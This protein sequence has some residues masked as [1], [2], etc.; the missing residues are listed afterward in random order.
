MSTIERALAPIQSKGRTG[1][2]VMLVRLAPLPEELS[3]QRP[4]FG[5]LLKAL[6][7]GVRYWQGHLRDVDDKSRK[8]DSMEWLKE[9]AKKAAV[10][11]AVGAPMQSE[12]KLG[13]VQEYY[14]NAIAHFVEGFPPVVCSVDPLNV[15]RFRAHNEIDLVHV[16]NTLRSVLQG[17]RFAAEEVSA[18]GFV[19]WVYKHRKQVLG[20]D[21]ET[22][23]TDPRKGDIL[24][25]AA[26]TTKGGVWAKWSPALQMGF[27]TDQR[28]AIHNS[29]F[30]HEWFI[31]RGIRLGQVFDTYL[32]HWLTDESRSGKL[33][34]LA[35]THCNLKPY[36]EGVD[37]SKTRELFDADPAKLG[38]YNVGDSVAGARLYQKL[39]PPSGAIVPV[40]DQIGYVQAQLRARGICVNRALMF[41]QRAKT[42][43]VIDKA[44][45]V[46]A[47]RSR[48]IE[49]SKDA[50]VV[51]YVF[52]KL[53]LSCTEHTEDGKRSAS[54][55]S[56]RGTI[57]KHPEH[58]TWLE[59]LIRLRL[60]LRKMS[61]VYDPFLALSESD[62]Y[63]HGTLRLGVVPSG[64]FSSIE[65]NM[66]NLDR[67][68]EERACFVSRFGKQGRIVQIDQKQFE[69]R[70]C[71][72]YSGDVEML[73]LF[74]EDIDPHAWLG[75]EIGVERQDGKTLNFS[76]ITGMTPRGLSWSKGWPESKSRKLHALW[77]KKFEGVSDWHNSVKRHLLQYGEISGFMGRV[78][79]LYSIWSKDWKEARRAHRQ[80][81]SHLLQSGADLLH[82]A[83]CRIN[84]RFERTLDGAYVVLQVHDSIVL[85][86]HADVANRAIKIASEEMTQAADLRVPLLVDVKTKESL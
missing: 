65:P 31:S 79:R 55:S 69:M 6:P 19:A 80:G 3:A 54:E 83:I 74:K 5:T 42:Q 82:V 51:A 21:I 12:F 63:I 22:E 18:R 47:R 16:G 70:L 72:H 57:K 44:Q 48:V 17:D 78:R 34:R 27:P 41:K 26:A 13:G 2:L 9:Q 77:H 68:G 39:N 24:T 53:G 8:R 36:W 15:E 52:D 81:I 1:A 32:R 40:M 49:W 33:E 7:V 23:G 43:A 14:D 86:V 46:L 38:V 37:L 75:Q 76:L 64:R 50:Q 62:G 58:K 29:A 4:L 11:V 67:D 20:L 59:H 35:T 28:W 30:E 84:D 71:A 45:K 61:N 10:L 66:Q 85:D 73:R 56:L 60:A 25:V